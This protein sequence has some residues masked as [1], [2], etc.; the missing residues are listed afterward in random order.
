[1]PYVTV[2]MASLIAMYMDR[3]NSWAICPISVAN[4][5]IQNKYPV[6]ICPISTPI[7]DR[8]C[9]MLTNRPAHEVEPTT[10]ALFRRELIR[11][12]SAR[13]GFR[14]LLPST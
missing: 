7:P 5:F 11:F 10:I 12:L 3:P 13:D 9:Y 2:D 6:Q 1:M 4:S 14:V 8:V